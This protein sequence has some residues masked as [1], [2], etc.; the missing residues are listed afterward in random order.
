[1]EMVVTKGRKGRVCRY[2]SSDFRSGHGLVSVH[3]IVQAFVKEDVDVDMREL[4]AM[5]WLR[6][7][8]EY[9]EG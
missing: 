6:R 9:N 1:M 4:T 8:Q 3:R 2:C 7:E 5:R